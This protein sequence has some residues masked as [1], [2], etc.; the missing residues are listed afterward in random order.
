MVSGH[1][2]LYLVETSLKPMSYPLL[3]RIHSPADVRVL[4]RRQLDQLA[5]ELRGFVLESVSRTGG[6]L[7][8]NLGTVELT[9]SLHHVFNLP[10]DRIIWDVGHQSYPHKIL[11]GRKQAMSTLRHYGGLS[12]F[13][14]RS[15]SEYDAF[16]TAHSSTSISAALGMAVASRNTGTPREHI[17]VIGDG[18][19]TAGMAFEAM[20]NAGVTPDIH[21]LVILNDNDMSI[22]PPVGALNRYL[23]RLMSGQFYAAAKN[24]GRAVLQH[25]PPVL[26]LARR[27]EEHAK[28]MVTPAT[29]FEE[30]GFNYVGPVDGHDLDS[31]IPTLQNMKALKGPQF[32]HVVTKKGQGYKLAEADP[33]LYHGPGKFDPAVGIQKSGAAPKLTFTQVFGQWLCDM[34]ERD[35]RLYG[36]TP[37]MREGSGLVEFEKRFPKRYFDVGIAE[38]HAVTFAAGLA[39]EGQKP[40]VAIYSTFLQ[41]GYDQLIHDVALQ[42][43]DVTFALDRA[44]LVG[45]D[46]ATH[47][48]NYDIAYLRCIPN[49]V[50]ACPS[51]EA[52]ARLLLTTCYE[53][54][55]PASVRY[56]RGA[57]VGAVPGQGLES[58]PLG[59]GVVRRRGQH[60][61][62][63]VFGTLMAV[64]RQA[65][66]A[67]DLTLVDMRF[68]KPIDHELIIQIASEHSAIVTLEEGS[69]MGGAGSAVAE[70]LAAAGLTVPLLQLGLPDR[71]IDHGEQATLLKEVGL[72]AAGIENAVRERF[73]LQK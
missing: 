21:L 20:N 66:Q 40:V 30:M 50:V 57:G 59:R 67:L 42:D 38:Q 24:V 32:L 15:E 45:A 56:P 70:S 71:F 12:G 14:K 28:G 11:T 10:H 23:A 36:I 63:L 49:M 8:S 69:I 9:I 65:A 2:G 43:L 53:H 54:P 64:A 18:S 29:L 73:Y 35:S 39:C 60:V 7:S 6:H 27:F 13:P 31:L 37:A 17:A 44:G 22:S 4:D 72:D 61:A 33:V 51:D 46:G 68:V 26:E 19:M 16:G 55:G 48:G 1:G 41:R 5:A 25:M 34:G 52:E 3:D 47:A 62:L 58:V